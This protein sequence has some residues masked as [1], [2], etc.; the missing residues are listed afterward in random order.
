MVTEAV[1][2]SEVRPG[3]RHRNLRQTS[4]DK[5]GARML[6]V[7]QTCVDDFL[8]QR[9]PL[10]RP[11]IGV[12][13]ERCVVRMSRAPWGRAMIVL[14]ATTI[15][16][17]AAGV[18]G[19]V[20]MSPVVRAPEVVPVDASK[21]WPDSPP[22]SG[23]NWVYRRVAKSRGNPLLR[24]GNVYQ[25]DGIAVRDVEQPGRYGGVLFRRDSG[26]SIIQQSRF[27]RGTTGQLLTRA[28]S[29]TPTSSTGSPWHRARRWYWGPG[30]P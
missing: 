19:R 20:L 16:P 4:S 18:D 25:P 12:C 23:L 14:A 22:P 11:G 29:P 5:R 10:D 27:M 28:R 21:P 24:L 2:D 6:W 8:Y 9:W 3:G 13:L 26:A 15:V 1:A 30:G 17:A 7:L